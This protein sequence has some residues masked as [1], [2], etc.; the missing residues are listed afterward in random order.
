[1][2]Y[3][4]FDE[5]CQ[6]EHPRLVGAVSLYC[7]DRDVALETAQEAL[8]RACKRWDDV[9]E[10][11]RPGAWVHRVAMNLANSHFRRWKLERRA[12]ARAVDQA[13]TVDQQPDSAAAVTVRRAVAALPSRQRTAVV[14]R[15]FLDWP[16]ADVAEVLGVSQGAVKSLTHRGITT[17]RQQL[18]DEDNPHP[19]SQEVRHAW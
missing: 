11:Q 15:Y 3:E 19:T 2:G 6:R 18:A 1:M 14:L 16:V 13:P 17:L 5:F 4:D 8:I 9:R 12:R 7:G 10:M